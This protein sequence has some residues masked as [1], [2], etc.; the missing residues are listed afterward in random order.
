M[1]KKTRLDKIPAKHRRGVETRLRR[2]SSV[3]QAR[4]KELG[5]TQDEL[6]EKLDEKFWKV[7]DG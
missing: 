5:M 7:V 6:A 4:R 3:I 1:E 2:I